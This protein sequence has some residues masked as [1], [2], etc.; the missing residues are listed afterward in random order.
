MFRVE[1]DPHAVTLTVRRGQQ[2]QG[3]SPL[4]QSLG[5]EELKSSR[6]ST[7]VTCPLLAGSGPAPGSN[8]TIKKLHE[9]FDH[10]RT[11]RTKGL[12]EH[13]VIHV[14]AVKNMFFPV[15]T[16]IGAEL[17]FLM[18]GLVVTEQVFNLNGLGRLLLESVM[19]HDYNITLGLVVIIVTAFVFLNLVAD[20]LH[21]WLDPRIRY[22]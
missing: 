5:A 3:T 2:R 16:A 20:L 15:L 13:T 8:T 17:A 6:R 12:T 4:P 9:F 1:D 11:A 14:H 21:A 10:I 7:Q 19:N 22:S 18:G